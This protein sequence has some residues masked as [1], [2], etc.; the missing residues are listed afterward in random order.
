MQLGGLKKSLFTADVETVIKKSLVSVLSMIT[1]TAQVTS[2]RAE[3]IT[4]ASGVVAAVD[5]H[6]TLEIRLEG[7]RAPET[8]IL[9]DYRMSTEA[10]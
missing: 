6:F 5:V 3:N 9:G 7:L 2:V 8:T 4:D 1:D 10:V